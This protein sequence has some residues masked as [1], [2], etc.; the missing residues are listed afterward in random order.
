MPDVNGTNQ[1]Y[2][3]SRIAATNV[4]FT[5]GGEDPWQWASIRSTFTPA[6]PARVTNCTQCAHCVELYTPSDNDDPALV[7][8]REMSTA[9]VQDWLGL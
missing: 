3:G 2:G 8:T 9:Y 1:Y 4:F 6:E 5:N 7:Q